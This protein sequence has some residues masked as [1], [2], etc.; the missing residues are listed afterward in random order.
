MS[1]TPSSRQY[2]LFGTPIQHSLS[3]LFH[4]A[5]F[6]ALDLPHRYE[7][8]ET[9]TFSD[10]PSILA[11][12]RPPP[13]EASIFAFSGAAVTMP[14]KT[15]VLPFMDEL[16][17]EVQEIGAMNTVV[18]GEGGRL[19][20]RNTD[21]DGIR[22]ALLSTRG[23]EERGREKPFGAGRSAFII[24]GGGT[25]RAAIYALSQLSLSPIYLLNR[26]AS[27]T[28]S[29]I[30]T[31]AFAKYDLRPLDDDVLA[32]WTEEDTKNVVCAVGAIP[33]FEP[34]TEGEKMVYRV[35][36][37]IF[38]RTGKLE[39]RRPI[40]EMAYKPHQT[41]IYKLAQK[42]GWSPIGGIEALIH[43][44]TTQQ[45]YW[46]IDSPVT[47]VPGLTEEKLREA[48]EVAARKVREA[49]GAPVV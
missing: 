13:A 47:R 45:R 32:S 27:E 14:Y 6:D 24:G 17:S 26:D 36:E 22:E 7:R 35:A 2:K 18:R 16:G 49:A 9:P 28:A 3:P 19:V 10:D 37:G 40:M 48:V 11:L 34:Q 15:A 1:S 33:S 5:V 43:Q 38:E 12:L 41:L 39:G 21:V 25:T 8:H 20:G 44:A 29:I 4:N 30:S 31:P 42:H 23:E 46:L